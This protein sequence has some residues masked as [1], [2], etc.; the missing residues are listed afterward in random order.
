[1]SF[2]SLVSGMVKRDRGDGT[3]SVMLSGESHAN[4][5][6]AAV[7][8]L[9]HILT[10]RSDVRYEQLEAL[11]GQKV[12]LLTRG[13]GTFG[14]STIDTLPGKVFQSRNGLGILPK[15][16]RTKGFDL[17]G[18]FQKGRLLDLE[19]GYGGEQ[20]IANRIESVKAQLPTLSP[21]TPEVLATLPGE[22]EDR[23]VSVAV[24]GSYAFPEG[25]I[26]GAIW[27]LYRRYEGILDGV[28]I[29]PPGLAESENGSVYERD[30]L[31]MNVG[32]IEGFGGMPFSEALDLADPH[33]SYSS[34]LARVRA[35]CE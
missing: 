13:T 1:M 17:T 23:D 2:N 33:V 4:A 9:Y 24:L 32:V 20:K 6:A 3:F 21:L 30:L 7:G 26:H 12:T 29:V 15:G 11:V 27:L 25:P 16:K 18:M 31:R 28:L 14:H 10:D 5:Y 35:A 19:L 34:A 8:G 22:F